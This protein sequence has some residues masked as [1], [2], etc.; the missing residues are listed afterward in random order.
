MV[1]TS[2][3]SLVPQV[4]NNLAGPQN[5]ILF[6]LIIAVF[7]IAYKVLKL[8][9]ETGLMSFLSIIYLFVLRY[10]GLGPAITIS[11]IILFAFLGGFLYLLYYFIASSIALILIPLK[12][13][14]KAVSAIGSALGNLVTSNKPNKKRKKQPKPKESNQEKQQKSSDQDEQPQTEKEEARGKEEKKASEVVLER[15]KR[16]SKDESD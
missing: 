2:L 10:F 7:I 14:G 9:L 5:I 11:N 6:I 3:Q 16:G 4:T 8:I 13:I 1:Q 15:M 12:L